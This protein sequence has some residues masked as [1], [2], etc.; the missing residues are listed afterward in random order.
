[1]SALDDQLPAGVEDAL[2]VVRALDVGLVGGLS[3]LGGAERE[4][5]EGLGSLFAGTPLAPALERAAPG[6]AK[7][8]PGEDDIAAFA[9][10]RASLLGAVHDALLAQACAALGRDVP[11]DP[12][13]GPPVT[14]SPEDEAPLRNARHW[15]LELGSAGLSQ[16]SPAAVAPFAST[17]ETLAERPALQRPAAML[18]G[19]FDELA[20]SLPL[21]SRDDAPI[22]RWPDLWMQSVIAA[23]PT[24][25]VEEA[26]FEGELRPLGVELRHHDHAMSAVVHGVMDGEIVR[27]S[28][29]GWK[30]DALL[31]DEALRVLPAPALDAMTSDSVLAVGGVRRGADLIVSE[32]QPTGKHDPYVSIDAL[33]FPVAAPA[34]RH[35]IHLAIPVV[36]PECALREEGGA[37]FVDPLGVRLAE[38]RVS[39]L[40]AAKKGGALE[41]PDA[42]IG[43]LRWDAGWS[44]QPLDAKLGKLRWNLDE[45]VAAAR[46]AAKAT[47]TLSV[48]T[49]RASKLLRS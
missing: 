2:E 15:L 26:P 3:R 43:L 48:L 39:P 24:L 23:G 25:S 1:M 33:P 13:L 6:F 32:A 35:P 36:L 14:L 44:L 28:F 22:P 7:G 5:V 37:R 12:A 49:E 45:A 21:S 4:R 34:D 30:V 29:T 46:K 20:E 11:P 9:A 41:A 40:Y 38:E 16:I 42:M 18:S 31:G 47:D 27:A 17:L 10:A 19:F 8:T